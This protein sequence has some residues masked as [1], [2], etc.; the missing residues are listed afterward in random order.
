MAVVSRRAFVKVSGLALAAVGFVG[1]GSRKT[2]GRINVHE[3]GCRWRAWLDGEEVSRWCYEANDQEGYVLLFK[4]NK[5][6][7]AY[8]D[9]I[10]DDM[11]REKRFG[12]VR[13]EKT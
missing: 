2:Y 11:A 12:K 3:H 10:T 8:Y 4:Q 9:P 6:G 13:I 5:A 7:V 1:F